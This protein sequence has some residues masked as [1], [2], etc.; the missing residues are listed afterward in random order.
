MRVIGT[1]MMGGEQS[2]NSIA[3]EDAVVTA[4]ADTNQPPL[5]SAPLAVPH[6]EVFTSPGALRRF[7]SVRRRHKAA[8]SST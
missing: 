6:D 1:W 5:S 7:W 8:R 2:M 3:I 4:M